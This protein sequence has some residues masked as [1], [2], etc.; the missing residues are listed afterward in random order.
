MPVLIFRCR[1][2]G[3]YQY[4]RAGVKT[5]Q[6]HCGFRNNLDKVK[7]VA[8]AQDELEAA[9]IVRKFQGSGTDFSPMA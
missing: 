6:C 1:K 5:R 9:E 7:V 2:C 4:A 3:R 8:R